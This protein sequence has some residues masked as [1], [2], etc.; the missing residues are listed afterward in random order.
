MSNFQID[1]FVFC[2][3]FSWQNIKKH[4]LH[5]SI[6]GAV[7]INHIKR[8]IPPPCC[9]KTT[10]EEALQNNAV[11]ELIEN[12]LLC[13][14]QSETFLSG[15]RSHVFHQANWTFNTVK[16]LYLLFVFVNGLPR[17]FCHQGSKSVSLQSVC[18]PCIN[19]QIKECKIQDAN[20]MKPWVCPGASH[21]SELLKC[22]HYFLPLSTFCLARLALSTLSQDYT[23][24]TQ[25]SAVVCN[26]PYHFQSWCLWE[27]L[28]EYCEQLIIVDTR[29]FLQTIWTTHQ[30]TRIQENMKM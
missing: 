17:A 2:E 13:L 24:I 16:V 18:M 21:F 6:N 10:Q 9:R 25:F 22:R 30:V 11:C 1:L 3:M 19:T 28:I 15:Q 20:N 29:L 23:M 8:T 7:G 27:C 4:D 14:H 26:T 5:I 12:K